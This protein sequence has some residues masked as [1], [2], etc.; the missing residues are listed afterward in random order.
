V[1]A[2]SAS[3]RAAQRA[4]IQ[5]TA[6]W[7]LNCQSAALSGHGCRRCLHLLAVALQITLAVHEAPK[8]TEGRRRGFHALPDLHPSRPAWQAARSAAK[9]EMACYLLATA[10]IPFPGRYPHHQPRL[11]GH[12][13]R[14]RRN[15]CPARI[16]ARSS[17]HRRE[18]RAA[19]TVELAR[20]ARPSVPRTGRD[21]ELRL[22]ASGSKGRDPTTAS[23]ILNCQ[24]AALSGHDCR[25]C[26]PLLAVALQITFTRLTNP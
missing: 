4:G 17:G 26:L 6:S 24:S 14:E 3:P 7:I 5:T 10:P 20:E 23:W 19:R 1:I 21:C 22:A 11:P 25:R 9:R 15:A 13:R 18:R 8:P 12:P 2:N 16:G